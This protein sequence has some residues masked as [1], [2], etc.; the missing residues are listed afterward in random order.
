MKDLAILPS[1]S[2]GDIIKQ[3][4][5]IYLI[6]GLIQRIYIALFGG[7]IES[8]T[9]GDEVDSE[10]RLDYWGNNFLPPKHQFN[11]LTERTINEVVLNSS[12][13]QKIENVVKEDLKYLNDVCTYE[14]SV[15]IP[16]VDRVRIYISL[17]GFQGEDKKEFSLLYNTTLKELSVSDDYQN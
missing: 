3:N 5:D 14:V 16:Y 7:N 2:G 12:G 9:R 8:D 4:N 17:F 15:T 1:R 10:E 6:D 11:Y 13:L